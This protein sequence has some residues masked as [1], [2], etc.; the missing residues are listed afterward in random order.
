MAVPAQH[1]K[2]LP[3]RLGPVVVKGGMGRERGDDEIMVVMMMM[4]MTTTVTW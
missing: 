4:M 1:L 3:G 2:H